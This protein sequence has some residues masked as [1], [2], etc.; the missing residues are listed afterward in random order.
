[1]AIPINKDNKKHHYALT[2]EAVTT[3]GHGPGYIK[4]FALCLFHN[5]VHRM[6]NHLYI[7]QNV[8]LFLQ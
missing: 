7:L 4:L 2:W 8:T 3:H 5:T 1:M 6:H